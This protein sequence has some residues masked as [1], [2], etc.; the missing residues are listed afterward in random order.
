M[1]SELG[2][3]LSYISRLRDGVV[4]QDDVFKFRERAQALI[5][6]W[7]DILVRDGFHTISV[8]SAASSPG[9]NVGNQETKGKLELETRLCDHYAYAPSKILCPPY[10]MLSICRLFLQGKTSPMLW[11][12]IYGSSYKNSSA[13]NKN[14]RKRSSFLN[15]RYKRVD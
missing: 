3:V 11:P 5:N 6:L 14:Y 4:P 1:S 15:F 2:K 10:C 9:S 12:G 13:V 7:W 8:E